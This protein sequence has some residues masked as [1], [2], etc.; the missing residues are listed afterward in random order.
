MNVPQIFTTVMPML[1][2]IIAMGHLVADVTL[3]MVAMAFYAVVSKKCREK[4]YLKSEI[5]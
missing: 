1:F 5:Q 3:D 4:L 2:A